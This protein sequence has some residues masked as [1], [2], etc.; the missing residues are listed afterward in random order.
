MQ[1]SKLVDVPTSLFVFR[2]VGIREVLG[3]NSSKLVLVG[4]TLVTKDAGAR[5]TDGGRSCSRRGK[6]GRTCF[7]LG[8]Y[9]RIGDVA[10]LA[11]QREGVS[12]QVQYASA[13]SAG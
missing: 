8:R 12:K 3:Q 13:R 11:E 2:I 9:R 6:L 4:Q 10:V 1:T 7:V 5:G